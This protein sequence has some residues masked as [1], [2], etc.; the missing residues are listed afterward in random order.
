MLIGG[1][2]DIAKHPAD[3]TLAVGKEVIFE[4]QAT[5]AAPLMYTWL[6]DGIN[7]PAQNGNIL[8]FHVQKHG[9][10]GPGEY[11]CLV[12]NEFGTKKSNSA[13]LTVGQYNFKWSS[14]C[15]VC[16]SAAIACRM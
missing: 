10:R 2:P 5:G 1:C 15:E 8:K 14:M 13:K 9:Q 11:T 16:T 6:R 4:C 3:R 7:I 12:E